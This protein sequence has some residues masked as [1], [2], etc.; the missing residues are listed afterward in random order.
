MVTALKKANS[1][2]NKKWTVIWFMTSL[3]SLYLLSVAIKTL[4][5]GTAYGVWS[6]IGAMGSVIVGM[7][8]Y[9][10]RVSIKKVI[11][12]TLIIISIVG[13]KMV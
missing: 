12:V 3:T 8:F 9:N 2:K 13:L 7:V 1:F 6:G 11:L 10:E 4:P 5:L